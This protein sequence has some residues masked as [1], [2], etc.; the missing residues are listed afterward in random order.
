MACGDIAGATSAHDHAKLSFASDPPEEDVAHGFAAI[1]RRLRPCLDLPEELLAFIFEL[2]YADWEQLPSPFQLCHVNSRWRTVANSTRALWRDM[3]LLRLATEMPVEGGD[4][5]GTVRNPLRF[6][7]AALSPGQYVPP[8]PKNHVALLRHCARQTENTLSYFELEATS[9]N[10]PFR[11]EVLKIAENSA[12]TLV[13]ISIIS[14]DQDLAANTV[15][16]LIFQCPLLADL[17]ISTKSMSANLSRQLRE[18]IQKLPLPASLRRLRLDGAV[19]SALPP[20]SALRAALLQRCRRLESLTLVENRS[21]RAASKLANFGADCLAT[22]ADHLIEIEVSS[23]N[24][25]FAEAQSRGVLALPQLRRYRHV[26]TEF[27][28]ALR[29]P[30]ITMDLPALETVEGTH[31]MLLRSAPGVIVRQDHLFAIDPF[32]FPDWLR[33]VNNVQDLTLDVRIGK[34]DIL[35]V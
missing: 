22:C 12:P 33:E 28:R 27:D 20:E 6:P 34:G 5:S 14:K 35:G 7:P 13:G 30:S 31:D 23:C 25:M 11:R 32:H 29:K 15:F 3:R 26:T 1:G 10:F 19:T 8:G 4:H 9:A 21:P 24:E 18:Q 2:V 17:Q 16:E